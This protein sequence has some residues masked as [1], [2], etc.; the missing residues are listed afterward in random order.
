MYIS[1]KEPGVSFDALAKV[2]S[3]RND[4]AL[5]FPYAVHAARCGNCRYFKKGKCTLK[6]C[7]CMRERVLAHSCSIGEILNDC[8]S[9]VKDGAF[10][11]RL[12]IAVERAVTEKSVF[13]DKSHRKRFME[14]V[15][16][17]RRE[18]NRMVAQIYVLSASEALWKAALPHIGKDSIGYM[19]IRLD[20]D[21]PKDC[22][23][24][25]LAFFFAHGW[26]YPNLKDLADDE[27]VDFD[28]FRLVCMM[29]TLSRYGYE[30]VR[31]AERYNNYR[32][33]QKGKRR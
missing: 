19:S 13:L 22:D 21:A 11:Y 33:I 12:R 26:S 9:D 29:L 6:R 27:A 2:T 15:K 28:T 16:M 23:L 24:F 8:F 14:G 10:H 32:K 20:S 18:N 3:S 4:T 5:S 7:C 31:I 17:I 25:D 1:M 30:T